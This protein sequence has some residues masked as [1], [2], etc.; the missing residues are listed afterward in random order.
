MSDRGLSQAFPS[1]RILQQDDISDSADNVLQRMASS[2]QVATGVDLARG[3][4]RQGPRASLNFRIHLLSKDLP[5][6]VVVCF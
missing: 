2:P 1:G 4:L 5:K 3:G 6:G